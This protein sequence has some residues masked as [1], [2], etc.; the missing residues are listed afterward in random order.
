MLI[1]KHEVLLTTLQGAL[2]R[3]Y[4]GGLFRCIQDY[5][6]AFTELTLLGKKIW[7]NDGSKK[8][9]L[10]QNAQNFGMVDIVFEELVKNKSFVET[11]NF[12]RSHGVCHDKKNKDK[13]TRN[14]NITSQ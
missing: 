7:D 3:N 14:I 11:Y 5:K 10:F 2:H 9:W 6:D 12:L 8:F 13:A 4:I 1:L